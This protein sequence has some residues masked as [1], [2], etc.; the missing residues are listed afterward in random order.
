MSAS[1]ASLR[2]AVC[3]LRMNWHG[4]ENTRSII[5][6]LAMAASRQARFCLFPELAVTGVHRMIATVAKPELVSAWLGSI[7]EA[8]AAHSIATSVGAPTFG[9][10]GALHIAQLFIDETGH[11]VGVV[12]KKGLTAP[13]ATFF[14]PGRARPSI[15][16]LGCTWSAMICR[17]ID[18]SVEIAN[19]FS[20][21]KP[22]IVV[23]P[24]A[25]RPDP[26]KPRTDPPDH[27]QRAQ[28][29]ARQ[30]GTYV[31]QA[32][33]PNALNRPEE[34]VDGGQSVV[35]DPEG[36]ILLTLPRAQ[37]GLAVFHLGESTYDWY[38]QD[39]S[40]SAGEATAFRRCLPDGSNDGLQ[41][42]GM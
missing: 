30:C 37:P 6:A 1:T 5:D 27:V 3:Q 31:I 10:N 23:W 2:I 42:R 41:K 19:I 24:G 14:T 32:N 34:S 25:M 29:F 33:W 36:K 35:I 40:R 21:D 12:E 9:T 28:Q 17:E 15:K 39:A 18:D 38:A 11:L 22:E 26:D 16:A 8:C 13:E 7:R 4:D 20:L